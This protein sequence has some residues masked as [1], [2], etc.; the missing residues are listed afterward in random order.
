MQSFD[1]TLA[2]ATAKRDAL[3]ETLE[4]QTADRNP[5]IEKGILTAPSH[6]EKR[7]G[8]SGQ[9]AALSELT[10][11]D[12]KLLFLILAFEIDLVRARAWPHVVRRKVFA[13]GICGARYV[14]ALHRGLEAREG[15]GKGAGGV[16][17]GPRKI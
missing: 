10:K 17:S 4:T 16:R 13:I 12:P 5:A 15:R 1:R 3:R 14:A 7:A 6:V 8:L 9:L 11:D 2:E